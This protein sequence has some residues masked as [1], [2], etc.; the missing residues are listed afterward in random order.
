[1]LW[2]PRLPSPPPA[3]DRVV[4]RG[5]WAGGLGVSG[6]N[7]PGA[8]AAPSCAPPGFPAPPRNDSNNNKKN[9]SP[10]PAPPSSHPAPLCKQGKGGRVGKQGS[11]A[12]V[13]RAG[14]EGD[15]FVYNN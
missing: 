8:A 2:P 1:M 5:G 15:L 14:C 3:F 9:S 12:V 7:R 10:A 11:R 13:W 4:G 6:P